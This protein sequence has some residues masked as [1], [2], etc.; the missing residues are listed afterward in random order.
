M[1][2]DWESAITFSPDNLDLGFNKGEN[3]LCEVCNLNGV[4]EREETRGLTLGSDQM[5]KQIA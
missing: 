3:P 2:M 1:W 4:V 5:R